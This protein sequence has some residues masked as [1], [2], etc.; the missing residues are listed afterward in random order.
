MTTHRAV[1]KCLDILMSFAP[2]NQ[3][4]GTI[5]MS[6]KMDINKSTASRLLHVLARKGF[7]Q[8]N[9]KTK[10][11]QLGPSAILPNPIWM[12]SEINLM[13]LLLWRYSQ[14]RIPSLHISLKDLTAQ[15]WRVMLETY[16]HPMRPPGQKP[17]LH[18][19]PPG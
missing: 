4:M 18:S 17:S 13:R 3:E 7:L 10:K 14:E 15:T 9:L 11:F 8:Q 6:V 1:E 5:E 19:P 16:W 12:N 2:H